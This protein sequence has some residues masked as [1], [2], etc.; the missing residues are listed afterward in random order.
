MRPV[1]RVDPKLPVTSMQTYSVV[2]PL[3]THFRA[4]TCE[5]VECTKYVQGWVSPIDESTE[6][7]R[8]QAYY[9]RNHSGRHFTEDRNQMPGLTMFVFEAGQKCFKQHQTRLDRPELYIVRDG[10]WRG[11]PTGNCRQHVNAED[12]VDDFKN[13]QAELADEIQKG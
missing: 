1:N 2:A 9:I 10:D 8:A 7:G 5:E 13:H 11:N 6:L 4:A 3:S 12:W